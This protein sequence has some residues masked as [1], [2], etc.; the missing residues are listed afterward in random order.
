MRGRKKRHDD[1]RAPVGVEQRLKPQFVHAGDQ[2]VAVVRIT[3]QTARLSAFDCMQP[4]RLDKS[5]DG[6]RGRRET[7]LPRAVHHIPLVVH[8][9]AQRV[10][11]TFGLAQ[12]A[13]A[14]DDETKT[15]HAFDA[16]VR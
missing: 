10:A 9:E 13:L 6:M 3:G 5:R 11:A 7:P 8:I 1:R 12:R 15:W 2:H 14:R 16:L 4:E